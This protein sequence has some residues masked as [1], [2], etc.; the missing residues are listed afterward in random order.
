[1]LK[2]DGVYLTIKRIS[3]EPLPLG[4]WVGRNGGEEER[5]AS[6]PTRRTYALT[7]GHPSET[8]RTILLAAIPRGWCE[9]EG[10]EVNTSSCAPFRCLLGG[11]LGKELEFFYISNEITERSPKQIIFEQTKKLYSTKFCLRY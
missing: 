11:S 7:A 8:I 9:G 5:G 3:R 1:M 4:P 2:A 10:C 6:E